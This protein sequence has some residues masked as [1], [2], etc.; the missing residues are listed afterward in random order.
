M[1]MRGE[2]T[3]PQRRLAATLGIAS[4]VLWFSLS[5]LAQQPTRGTIAGNVTADQGKVIGLRVAAHNLDRR[6]WYIV[7]TGKGRYTI[8]QALPGRYEVTVDEPPYDSPK[9]SLELRPGESKTADLALKY[10]GEAAWRAEYGDGNLDHKMRSA[11]RGRQGEAEP[12]FPA[13]SGKIVNVNSLEELFPPGPALGLLKE[14]C[15]GCHGVGWGSLHYNRDQFLRGIEAMTETGYNLKRT[16]ISK[17]QKEMLADYLVKNFGAG[18]PERQLR[19]DLLV[20]DESVVSKQIYVSYDVPEDIPF[21]P[22][23]YRTEN[24]VDGAAPGVGPPYAVPHMVS[25]FVSPVDG[26]IWV[27]CGSCNALLRLNPTTYDSSERWKIYPIKGPNPHV[28][29]SGIAIDKQGHVWWSE[30]LIGGLV[31]ELDPA[32]GKQIRYALPYEGGAIHDV[33]VDKDGNI[34]FG[35]IQGAQFGRID[36]KTHQVHM[37]PTPTPDNG[38]Y[39][40]AADQHGNL[41]GG[42]WEKGMIIKW[43]RDTE[44]V[45]EYKVPNSWGMI[46]RITVDSKGIVW[47]GEY[48]SGILARFDPSTEKLTEYKI[49]LSGANPY[50]TWADR[51]DNI[52]MA[53]MLQSTMIKFEPNTGK[54]LFY[55]M[56]QPHQSVPKI[57]VA[58]D[59]TIW[60]GTRGKKV[61]TVVHLYPD[62]YTANAVPTP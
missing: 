7:F 1:A 11:P 15:T 5:S 25:T 16:P 22:G 8:P 51:S 49:P 30:D 62:G 32:T 27:S 61:G 48:N 56:P 41:W 55:P 37:Y 17:S 2:K 19:V 52:W 43:D 10:V 24:M 4:M 28:L 26:N 6:L 21:A 40:L 53:D 44:S 35:L 54:F 47:A 42:G 36:A 46:R 14:H 3:M 13:A 20:P 31:G 33:V 45:K 18:V 23:A 60:F 59:N 29:P 58:N 38:I 9:I 34:G 12:N 57:Q 39:G 50:E